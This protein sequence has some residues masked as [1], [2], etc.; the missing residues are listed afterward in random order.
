MTGPIASPA[1]DRARLYTLCSLMFDRPREELEDALADGA[2]PDV[3]VESARAIDDPDLEAAADSV[4]E[5]LDDVDFTSFQSAYG[6][7][8]GIETESAVSTYEMAYRPG[9]MVTNTDEL[10]DIAGFYQAFR[11]EVGEQRGRVDHLAIELEFLGE[12]TAREAYLED[13]GDEDGLEIVRDAQR[14][15]LEDHLGRWTPR[16]LAE[17][18][19]TDADERYLALA[20]LLEA[21]VSADVDRLDADPDV[22][23]DRPAG[24][25][26]SLFDDEGKAGDWRCGT[27]V[28]NPSANPPMAGGNDHA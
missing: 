11:L 25:L 4:A 9:G 17:L 15:F 20:R 8:F 13:A 14:S 19:D 1:I 3:L 23:E 6:E 16:L 28:G 24:P 26:E 2:I 12:L 21:L 18:E 5:D 27:C 22:F 10:A 7:T